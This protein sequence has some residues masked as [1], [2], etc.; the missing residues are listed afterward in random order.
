MPCW[1]C[2]TG[3]P[4]R[5][6][7]RS[8][9]M[10]STL[11]ARSG[12]ACRAVPSWPARG[13]DRSRSGRPG[14]RRAGRSPR[15]GAA[16]MPKC[17]SEDRKA[18]MLSGWASGV[19]PNSL[20][21]CT[22]VSRRPAESAHSSRRLWRPWTSA[23]SLATG[24]SARRATL[25]SGAARK[26]GCGWPAVSAR[27]RK[28]FSLPCSVSGSRNSA[29]GGSTGRSRSLLRKPYR[30]AVSWP[31]RCMASSMSPTVTVTVSSAR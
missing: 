9:T 25:T 27:R 18:S 13:T 7:D 31:K 1:A 22:S 16:A 10:A 19:T 26:S 2:T 15:T 14:R 23:R 3:S 6:S 29:D 28:S 21:I 4:A 5:S 24:S 20:S 17:A 8:R 11:L 12:R 30:L